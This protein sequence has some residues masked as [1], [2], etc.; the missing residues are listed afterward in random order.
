MSKFRGNVA[1]VFILCLKERWEADQLLGAF[2]TEEK[3]AE[4]ATKWLEKNAV[5]THQR[6]VT[7]VYKL[8]PELWD[9][10]TSVRN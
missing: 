1:E 6:L 9:V 4:F 8:D 10:G 3:S 5:G 7:E 2:S